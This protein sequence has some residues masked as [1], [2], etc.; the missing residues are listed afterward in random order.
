MPISR[1]PMETICM[2]L[3]GPLPETSSVNKFVLAAICLLTNYMFMVPIPNKTTQVIQAYLN[4]IYAQFG[5]SRYIL[6]DRGSEFTSQ[7][8]NW[9]L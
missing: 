9:V 6:M 2:D 8:M 1:I 7:M 3:I 5:G 4:H